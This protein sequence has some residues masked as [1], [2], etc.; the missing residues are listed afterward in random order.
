MHSVE[1]R[2]KLKMLKFH[3][4][5]DIKMDWKWIF[6]CFGMHFDWTAEG[7]VLEL[8]EWLLYEKT[9][10][11]CVEYK[12]IAHITQGSMYKKLS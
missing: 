7:W 1:Q 12:K 11:F 6:Y 3:P 8:H 9:S 2:V 4:F 10:I 5:L